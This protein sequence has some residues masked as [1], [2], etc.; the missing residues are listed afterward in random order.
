MDVAGVFQEAGYAHSSANTRSKCNFNISL[1]L[2]LPHPLD[3]FICAK[4]NMIILFL[5]HMIGRWE[6][7][8]G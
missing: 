5:Q 7:C 6:E 4:D 3:Y 1:F 8:M 2:T